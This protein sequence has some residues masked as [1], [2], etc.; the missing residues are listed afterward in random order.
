MLGRRR[1]FHLSL[2]LLIITHIITSVSL[3]AQFHSSISFINYVQH[4]SVTS[5]HV[6]FIRQS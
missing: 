1:K 3:L 2:F 4:G 5:Q 6:E